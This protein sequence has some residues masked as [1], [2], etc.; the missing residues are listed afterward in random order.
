MADHGLH[1][2]TPLLLALT[3]LALPH[4]NAYW[5]LDPDR[6]GVSALA[7][8]IVLLVA[9]FLMLGGV[10]LWIDRRLAPASRSAT[11]E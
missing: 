4:G 5:F 8:S 11:A 2:A 3:W 1:D 9:G 7:V 6:M 10:L